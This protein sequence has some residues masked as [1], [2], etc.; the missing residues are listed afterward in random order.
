MQTYRYTIETIADTKPCL[1]AVNEQNKICWLGFS[2]DPKFL[3]SEASRDLKSDQF[4]EDKTALSTIVNTLK[5]NVKNGDYS[6][7]N[8][9]F[10]GTPFQESVWNELLKIPCGKTVSY[11][12]IANKIGNPKAVRAVGTAVGANLVSLIIPCHRVIKKDGIIHNYRWGVDV[13]KDLLKTENA[14]LA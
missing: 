2:D 14:L 12:D 3:V 5:T 1:I 8:I 7:L 11:Q 10:K 9:H 4:L 13:K 6:D